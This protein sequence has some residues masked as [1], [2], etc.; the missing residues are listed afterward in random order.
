M[1]AGYECLGRLVEDGA[2][3]RAVE[4]MVDDGKVKVKREEERRRRRDSEM[5]VS[6]PG[7][8]AVTA[9]A[10]QVTTGAP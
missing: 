10:Q 4:S 7:Q 6:T 8:S 2:Q 9:G 3:L 5:E 1:V